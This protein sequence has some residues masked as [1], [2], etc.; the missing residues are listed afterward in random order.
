MISTVGIVGYGNFG[1]FLQELAGRFFPDVK[2]KIYSRRAEVD[3]EIFFSLEEVAA[4]DVIILCGAIREYEEQIKTVVKLSLPET[5]I[6]DVATV[7]KYTS[8]LL[9]AY[10]EGRRFLS[11]HPMFGPESYKKH[12]GT[13]NGFRIVV[14]DYVLANDQYQILKNTFATLGFLIIEMTADEH[15]KRLAET[16]FLTHYVG[17]SIIRAG[18]NRTAIDTLSFQFLMDAVESVKDDRELFKDVYKF[19]PYCTSVAE[20]LHAAQETVYKELQQ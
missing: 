18:F 17:Q 12:G 19:N 2:V 5:I 8:E 4:C 10:C 14:T 6:V 20:R 11:T 13:I 16:L 3:N 1:Q 7:K 15:D 9:R